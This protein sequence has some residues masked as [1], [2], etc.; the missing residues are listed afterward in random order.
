MC[1]GS[2]QEVSG[3][4]SR[5]VDTAVEALAHQKQ[6]WHLEKDA[7][8]LDAVWFRVDQRVLPSDLCPYV[9]RGPRAV[10]TNMLAS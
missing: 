6:L 10:A 1:F 8:W 5:A 9:K 7:G 2:L 4:V 3:C